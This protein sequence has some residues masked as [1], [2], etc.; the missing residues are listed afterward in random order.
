MIFNMRFFE[1]ICRN[2]V[3]QWEV[4]LNDYIK[5]GAKYIAPQK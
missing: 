1:A 5:N 2:H 4:L 3:C